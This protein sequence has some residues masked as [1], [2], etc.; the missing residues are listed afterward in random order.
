MKICFPKIVCGDVDLTHTHTSASCV[1]GAEVQHLSAVNL[2][3]D[4]LNISLLSPV[5]DTPTHPL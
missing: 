3:I 2:R 4:E 5:C 1:R